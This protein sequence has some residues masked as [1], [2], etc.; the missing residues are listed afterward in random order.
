VEGGVEAAV[1]QGTSRGLGKV[2]T[3]KTPIIYE[4]WGRRCGLEL[5]RERWVGGDWRENVD[6]GKVRPVA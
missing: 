1:R 3:F 6:L 2:R 4:V 5:E